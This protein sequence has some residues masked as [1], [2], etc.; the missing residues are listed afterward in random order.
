VKKLIIFDWDDVFT[1]G[2]TAGYH[3]CYHKALLGV[4]V[5]LSPEEEKAR[6]AKRWGSSHRE[7]LNELLKEHPKLLDKACEIY[8]RHL[9]GDTFVNELSLVEGVNNML[10]DLEKN[11]S[12]AIASGVNSKLLKERIMPYF[13]VPQVFDHIVT[14]YDLPDPKLSKPNPYMIDQI[15]RNLSFRP[16]EAVLVGDAENDIL[17]AKAANVEPIAVLTGHLDQKQAEKLGVKYIIKDVTRITEIL[18]PL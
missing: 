4:G 6:I 15:L 3:R 18:N 9:L 12:L 7:E 1:L 17:M 2:S 5:K 14:A 11:Y 13:E 16:Q 10:T 8:E